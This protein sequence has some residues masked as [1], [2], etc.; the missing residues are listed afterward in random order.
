MA[1]GETGAGK[2]YT[3]S[4]ATENYRLRGIIPRAIS[5][6]CVCAFEGGGGDVCISSTCIWNL[7]SL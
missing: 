2:T 6:V 4:G 5:Q 1:Y 7:N 3:M